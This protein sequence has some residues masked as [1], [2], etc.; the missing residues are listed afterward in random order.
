MPLVLRIERGDPPARTAVLEAAA[1]ASIAV[2]L[3]RRARPGGPW[4]EPLAEWIAGR[5]RKV[6]RRARGAHW[7]AVQ[8]LPGVTVAVDG[9]E[10][11]A[12][13][14]CPI[15]GAPK[16]VD[17]LQIAGT[18]LEPDVPGELPAGAPVLW[19]NPMVAMTVGKAAAQV[20]HASMLLAAAL[21]HTAA[22]DRLAAWA[23][24]GFRCAVRKSDV[25]SWARLVAEPDAIAVADAGYTE[26]P[27]HTITVIAALARMSTGNPASRPAP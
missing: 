14:P 5:I 3:D 13:L 16:E 27:P 22:F 19:L 4:H 25:E 20:G 23:A 2:C 18:E 15:G 24:S 26:I 6:A 9:A 8:R 12:L 7:Q 17:R 11:R 10:V 21:W 1:A